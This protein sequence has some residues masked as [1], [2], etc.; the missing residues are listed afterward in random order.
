MKSIAN[1]SENSV[2]KEPKS[3]EGFKKKSKPQTPSEPKIAYKLQLT[4]AM[5]LNSLELGETEME[6]FRQKFPQIARLLAQP[7][8]LSSSSSLAAKATQES[9]Q[10]AASQLLSAAWKIKEAHLFHSPVD[11][12]KLGIPDYLQIIKKPMDFGTIKV[13]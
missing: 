3:I 6:E 2:A 5:T 4:D 1:I 13:T 12:K 8:L 10:S 11:V 9:W 7:E